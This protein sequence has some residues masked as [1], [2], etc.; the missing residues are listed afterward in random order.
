VS[1]RK[2][3]TA[4]LLFIFVASLS[5]TTVIPMSID[6][7]NAASTHVLLG[8][9]VESWSTWDAE[10]RHIYTYTKFTVSEVLKGPA[11]QA[12]I[13]KQ[14]GGHA[15]GYQQKVAGI[16]Y[17]APGEQA[18]VFAHASEA[19]DNTLVITGLMQGNFR[20]THVNGLTMA[21]NGITGVESFDEQQH[22]VTHYTGTRIPL[23]ELERRVREGRR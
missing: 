19:N 5:A 12:V 16:R 13:L 17:F 11:A 8:R 21:S 6:Q 10:H 9:A 15:E 3:I 23:L 7:L 18:V 22:T 1:G 20:L 2:S 14:M 4:M